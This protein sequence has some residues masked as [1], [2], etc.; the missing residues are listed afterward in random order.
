MRP[1][2]LDELGLADGRTI[3]IDYRWGDSSVDRM[4]MLVKGG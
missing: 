4:R 1:L 3:I 2:R